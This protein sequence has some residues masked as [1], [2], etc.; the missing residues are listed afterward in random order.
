ME[1][2]IMKNR[3][4]LYLGVALL[5]VA[6]V[7]VLL[8]MRVA[9]LLPIPLGLPLPSTPSN[10]EQ[11]QA[12]M[13]IYSGDESCSLPCFWGFRPGQTRVE[14]IASF[15]PPDFDY[16]NLD[17]RYNID[18]SFVEDGGDSRRP[19][20]WM[21]FTIDDGLLYQTEVF[22]ENP[23]NWL[24]VETFELPS[25]LERTGSPTEAY[26]SININQSRVFLGLL[27]EESHSL[28]QYSFQL[29]YEEEGFSPDVPYLLCPSLNFTRHV[30]LWLR[31]GDIGN[32][33]ETA[34]PEVAINRVLPV[35]VMTNLNP[36]DFTQQ[37]VENPDECI[38]L[39]S[40][41]EMVE[42]G[43]GY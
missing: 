41:N 34:R 16:T 11:L 27:F 28:A 12:L 14:E 2:S 40:M 25:F 9:S 30:R 24:P 39:L 3:Q 17:H 32:L 35:E 31:D 23:A 18:Y 37:V 33:R 38:E 22:L 20:M 36:E 5:L 7:G 21:A 1:F 15:S 29:E 43:F 4:L 8:A 26:V 13:S 10:L 42:Q 6:V 19:T